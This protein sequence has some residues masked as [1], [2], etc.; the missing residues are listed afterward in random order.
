MSL[1]LACGVVGVV[2]HPDRKGSPVKN[3]TNQSLRVQRMSK[4]Y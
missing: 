4:R 1:Q 2:R 3:Q